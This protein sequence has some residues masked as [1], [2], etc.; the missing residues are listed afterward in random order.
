M[1]YLE[2]VDYIHSIPKFTKKTELSNTIRLLD[3]LGIDRMDS[4]VIHVAGTN[5][6]GSTCAFLAKILEEAGYQT[7]LF[8]SPHLID[9]EER[10]QINQVPIA[11]DEFCTACEKVKEISEKMVKEGY[12]HPAYFEFLFGLRV[13]I[14]RNISLGWELRVHKLLHQGTHLY[15]DP[16]YIPGFGTDGSLFSGAF[17]VSYTLPLQRTSKKSTISEMEN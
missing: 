7:A 6:K 17:S 8:T 11:R 16:W 14:W 15:G 2:C 13:Q 5:G 12:C 3:M 4:R 1:T 9:L 10:I